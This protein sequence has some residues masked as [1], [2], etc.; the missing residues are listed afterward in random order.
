MNNGK[1]KWAPFQI[2]QN[3]FSSERYLFS[4]AESEVIFTSLR[5]NI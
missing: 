2:K 3:N 1:T 4:S 5:H